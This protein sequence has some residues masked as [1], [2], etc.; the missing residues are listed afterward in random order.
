MFAMQQT[1]VLIGMWYQEETAE[2]IEACDLLTSI[3]G[4]VPLFL[5]VWRMRFE[6]LMGIILTVTI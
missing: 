1:K 3:W 5:M 2:L 4:I 6:V